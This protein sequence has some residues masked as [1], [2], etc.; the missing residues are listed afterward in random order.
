MSFADEIRGY[1]PTQQIQK[2]R[3]ALIAKIP[4]YAEEAVKRSAE[5]ATGERKREISGFLGSYYDRDSGCISVDDRGY[6]PIITSDSQPVLRIDR[7]SAHLMSGSNKFYTMLFLDT[8]GGRESSTP[9]QI[10]LPLTK[11]ELK[12]VCA[13]AEKAIA[14]LGFTRFS[15]KTKK[16]PAE[17]HIYKPVLFSKKKKPVLTKENALGLYITVKW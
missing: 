14:G 15:V 13:S 12:N 8:K 3:A 11:D 16:F 4:F 9:D 17:R 6:I 5:L 2:D 10:D 1:D 7:V